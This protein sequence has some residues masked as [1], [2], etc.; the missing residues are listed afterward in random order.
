VHVGDEREFRRRLSVRGPR[1]ITPVHAVA[2][3]H[4]EVLQI[5]EA[6]TYAFVCRWSAAAPT[7]TVA[8]HSGAPR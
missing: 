3:E 2:L 6:D 1:P 4:P 5:R 8:S 7:G